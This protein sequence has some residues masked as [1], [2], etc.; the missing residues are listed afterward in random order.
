MD[1]LLLVLTTRLAGTVA[2]GDIVCA[3]SCN[4]RSGSRGIQVMVMDKEVLYSVE[5]GIASVY[6][7]RPDARNAMSATVVSGLVKAVRMAAMDPEVRVLVLGGTGDKAFCAGADLS[8]MFSSDPVASGGSA[9]PSKSTQAT[10]GDGSFTGAGDGTGDADGTAGGGDQD[11]IQQDTGNAGRTSGVE[12]GGILGAH[13]ARGDIVRLFKEMWSMGKPTIARVQGW[14][15]AGGFG[16]AMACDM[17]VASEKARFGAPEVNVGLW[18]FIITVPLMRSM[19]PKMALE[20]ML[21]GRVV[22]AGEG[23]ELGF[24]NRVVPHDQLDQAV[25]SLASS[26]AKCSPALIRLGRDSFYAVWGAKPSDAFPYLQTMLTLASM[27]DDAREGISAFLE[28]R[29][30]VWRGR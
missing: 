14:A 10:P 11:A 25:E 12:T 17:V 27:T 24:V 16:L 19:P 7:N 29:E 20:L 1:V 15:L 23:K 13:E 30:P 6:I 4:A 28:K 2:L 5:N 26:M 9:G 3:V 21:T 22:D 18:P 8:S